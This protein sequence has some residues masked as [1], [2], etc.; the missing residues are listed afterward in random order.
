MKAT[1]RTRLLFVLALF[2]CSLA[3]APPANAEP[4]WSAE[5]ANAWY[6]KTGWLVG[7]NYAPATAI[8][9]LEMWQA[10]TFDLATIDRELGWAESLGFNSIRVFLHDQLWE[11][12]PKG[13]TR[14]MDQ[15]LKVAA[16]HRIGVMFVLF[17]SVW[18]PNPK[19]GTQRAPRPHVH[20]SGWVQSPGAA[21]LRDPSRHD[22]LKGY[23]QGV[24]RRFRK[25]K[26]IHAWDLIN[27]PDN[28]NGNSYGSQEPPNKPALA[29]ALLKK[30][31]AWA[32]EVDPRQPLTTGVWLGDWSSPEKMSPLDRYQVEE[33]DII[34]FHNYGDL[35][36]MTRR[37][38]W[39]R[40]YG[41]PVL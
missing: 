4:R 27:E 3:G 12:D 14:R 21:I 6:R 19:L 39:L 20:N 7:C 37:V 28:T 24:M 1:T 2:L 18:D 17:D 8:N 13:F 26:R 25:D 16:K 5:Q 29:F 36:E 41:R 40:R 9:Q 23:V 22:S 15:F 10:D 32:R 34:T 11:Q 33:A 31:Y 38:Q 35:Q 30:V